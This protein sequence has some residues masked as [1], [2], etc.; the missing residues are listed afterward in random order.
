MNYKDPNQLHMH[1]YTYTYM[2][3]YVDID[4]H[5]VYLIKPYLFG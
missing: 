1:V 4:F 2:H 3:V 5:R